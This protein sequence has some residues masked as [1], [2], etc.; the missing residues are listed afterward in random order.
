MKKSAVIR[1]TGVFVDV[2]GTLIKSGNRLDARLYSNME[3]ARQRGAQVVIFTMA[4]SK[5]MTQSLQKVG[6][7]TNHFPVKNKHKYWGHA[8]TGLVI[9]DVAPH[10]QRFLVQ[11]F[12][13]DST[14]LILDSIAKQLQSNPRL[15]FNGALKRYRLTQRRLLARANALQP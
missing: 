14:G 6:V 15:T 3:I 12:V 11:P 9:D 1:E 8:F 10:L 2:Q 13:Y 4:D 7:N 5:S